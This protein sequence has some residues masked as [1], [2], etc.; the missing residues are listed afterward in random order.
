MTKKH[1]AKAKKQAG[2]NAKKQSDDAAKKA[3]KRSDDITKKSKK[4]KK[5][6]D[7]G[8]KKA[9]KQSDDIAKKAKKAKKRE[10]IEVPAGTTEQEI[11]ELVD[12]EAAPTLDGNVSRDALEGTPVRALTFLRAIGTSA[13]IHAAMAA[14]GYRREHHLEGWALLHAVC[15]YH[16]AAPLAEDTSS[17]QDA[18][19]QLDD[20]DE[21][22][23]Q[24]I[25]ASLRHRFPEQAAFLLNG[26]AP[27]P[28]AG[29]VVSVRRLL[30]RLDGLEYASDRQNSRQKD[31][32]AL[33]LLGQRGIDLDTR[34]RLRELIAVAEAAP[35]LTQPD[36]AA[37]AS[38]DARCVN[39]LMA[40]RAWFEEWL[41]IAR[42]A[43]RR[44][45]HLIRLGLAKRRVQIAEP[46][47]QPTVIAP[48]G[49]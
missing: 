13:A 9:K 28:D 33:A 27:S 18:I 6:S 30:D 38:A 35:E 42:V 48:T 46:S 16:D 47:S 45:D 39:G 8:A 36:T 12:D 44:R 2:D 7:D 41:G 26:L 14:C 17:I 5:L 34:R 37:V 29:V 20:W 22:G 3:K 11:P 23:F 31:L 4:A 15:G 40:L 1:V 49:T 43:I 19:K 25:A 21:E 24:I 10:S 32:E